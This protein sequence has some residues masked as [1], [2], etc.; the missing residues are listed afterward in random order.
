MASDDSQ[1]KGRRVSFDEG[2]ATVNDGSP[3]AAGEGGDSSGDDDGNASDGLPPLHKSSR[4]KGYFTLFVFALYNYIAASAKAAA[5]EESEN[6]SQDLMSNNTTEYEYDAK[7]AI[8]ESDM[9][10]LYMDDLGSL[11]ELP[12][13]SPRRLGYSMAC[14]M[15]TLIVVGWILLFHLDCCTPLRKSVW[16]KV[17]LGSGRI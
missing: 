7:A 1:S 10:C 17:C 5:V 14:S 11:I 6:L 2:D 16:P 9:W 3:A 8:V 15:I 4:I 13:V 12:L